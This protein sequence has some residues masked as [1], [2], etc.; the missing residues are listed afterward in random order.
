RE[1]Y[2][3]SGGATERE[4]FGDIRYADA[5]PETSGLSFVD[6]SRRWRARAASIVV[7]H[8][9]RSAIQLVL[10]ARDLLFA[11]PVLL[12]AFQQGFY[13]PSPELSALWFDRRGGAL[14][15]MLAREHP[16]VFAIALLSIVQLLLV[17]LLFVWGFFSG[18]A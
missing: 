18:R 2:F 10:F 3:R 13:H 9:A 4:V 8:P 16:A 14:L 7:A 11:P 15:A 5:Y 17:S 1:R 6:L 12:F